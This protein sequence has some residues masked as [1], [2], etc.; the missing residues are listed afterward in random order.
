MSYHAPLLIGKKRRGETLSAA[1]ISWWLRSYMQG[2]V[3]EEQMSAMLM[4]IC[5]RGLEMDELRTFTAEM[6]N[7][8]TRLELGNEKYMVDKH[9]TGGVGDKISL[10]LAPLVATFGVGVP[11]LSGRGLGHTGG[12]LDKLESIPGWRANL[13]T[14]E[15]I[16]LL[17]RVGA[18]ICAAGADLAPADR[19]LYSLRDVTSTVESIPLISASIMSKKI[20]EGTNG[21]VLDVKFG[22]GAFMENQESALEL[23]RTMVLLGEESGVA[24]EALVTN[25]HSP[26]GKTAGNAIEVLECLEVLAGRGP[27]DVAYLTLELAAQMLELAGVACTRD[28]IELRLRDGSALHKFEEMVEAQG[29]TSLELELGGHRQVVLAKNSGAVSLNAL[30]IGEA[31]LALGAGRALKEDAVDFGAG[32]RFLVNEGQDVKAGDPLFEIYASSSNKIAAGELVLER[33]V[34][35][36]NAHDLAAASGL[37]A[38]HVNR[39]GSFVSHEEL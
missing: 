31:T 15:I 30:A 23:A 33:A 11:Q 9:S 10:V 1:E 16:E 12:T 29:G 36:D 28:E 20:A 22:N 7:S 18:V 25:M 19:R 37:V 21:L 34:S 27:A 2:A 17:D 26:L 8:G 5:F 35:Y 6:V 13:G 38:G 4:A 32:V 3:A 39:D 24:C 14:A